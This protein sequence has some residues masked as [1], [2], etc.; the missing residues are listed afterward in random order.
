MYLAL[1]WLLDGWFGFIFWGM[2]YLSLYPGKEK[3]ATPLRSLET[4]VNYFLILLGA[5]VLVAGTYVRTTSPAM[6]SLVSDDRSR[7]Q[8]NLSLMITLLILL[9]GFGHVLQMHSKI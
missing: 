3:W 1:A 4:L 7:P 2:A 8:Y 9:E 6:T 5:Y